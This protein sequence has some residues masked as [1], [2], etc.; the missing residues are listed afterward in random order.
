MA[1][2][3]APEVRSESES[4]TFDTFAVQRLSAGIETD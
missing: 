1:A 3:P 4:E 2:L